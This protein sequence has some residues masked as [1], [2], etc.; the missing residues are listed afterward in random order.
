VAEDPGE[1]VEQEVP[2]GLYLG[3]IRVSD[4]P[5]RGRVVEV[6]GERFL[7][8]AVSRELAR[9]FLILTL[10]LAPAAVALGYL[11]GRYVG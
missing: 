6:D 8:E 5:G 11:I 2:L 4:I 1:L 10:V 7:P 3:H 9:F